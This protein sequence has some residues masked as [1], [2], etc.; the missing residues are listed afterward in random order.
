MA[1]ADSTKA[2]LFHQLAEY[3]AAGIPLPKAIEQF[4]HAAAFGSIRRVLRRLGE[5]LSG[6]LGEDFRAVGFS[7][8][9]AAMIDAG[10]RSG[11]LA[12]V[13]RL[14][15]AHYIERV[16]W[17]RVVRSRLAYPLVVF[18]LAVVLLAIPPAVMAADPAIF[19]HQC[20]T[21]FG[22]AYGLVLLLALLRAGLR[23]LAARVPF[24]ERLLCGIPFWGGVAR[25]V[26]S[27]RFARA[28]AMQLQA[29]VTVLAAFHLAA[30]ASGS[31][32]LGEEAV[33]V[34]ER[35]RSGSGLAAALD[36]RSLLV[37]ELREAIAAGEHTGR[38]D[39][40]CLRVA[41]ELAERMQAWAELTATWLPRIIYFAVVGFVG[42]R[43]YQTLSA[44]YA[45]MGALLE[46]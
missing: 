32:A 30:R 8:F 41:A 40:Q 21:I 18:H 16:K 42:W 39:S 9:D 20:L 23:A 25:A 13:F 17:R 3:V 24:I 31:R 1:L 12:D 43:I 35:V 2:R 28:F 6:R 46:L 19:I 5:R 4:S 22:I 36:R 27:E 38:M 29:G 15:E 11:R 34:T 37:P 45:P 44:V 26:R 14:L 10:E 7:E 33:K